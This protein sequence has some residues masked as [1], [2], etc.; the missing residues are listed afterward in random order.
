MSAALSVIWM[1]RA[2]T[3]LLALL[4]LPIFCPNS[5]GFLY[6]IVFFSS[7]FFMSINAPRVLLQIIFLIYCLLIHLAEKVC[8]P[9]LINPFSVSKGLFNLPAPSIFLWLGRRN[10]TNYSNS[11]GSHLQLP[12]K[13]KPQNLL[14][15]SASSLFLCCFVHLSF[16]ALF[17][18][19]SLFSALVCVKGAI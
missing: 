5:T 3:W 7:C 9:P 14:F 12:F 13:K 6:M 2:Y 18:F 17:L 19:Y 8:T 11:S 10:G 4:V 16:F 1:Q 15:Q